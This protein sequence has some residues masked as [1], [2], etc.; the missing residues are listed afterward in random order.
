MCRQHRS[1]KKA[2]LCPGN[3]IGGAKW[4]PTT[5]PGHGSAFQRLPHRQRGCG[6]G[7]GLVG[8]SVWPFGCAA[9]V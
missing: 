1:H 7:E 4:H 9:E 5:L 6:G 2:L 8:P 3:V